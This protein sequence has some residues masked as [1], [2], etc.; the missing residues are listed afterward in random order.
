MMVERKR[1][2]LDFE[3]DLTGIMEGYQDSSLKW[4]RFYSE[5]PTNPGIVKKFKWSNR[6][7][8]NLEN[9][10]MERRGDYD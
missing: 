9:H 10:S 7:K 2:E 5:A 3:N 8:H 6:S 4:V 1:R